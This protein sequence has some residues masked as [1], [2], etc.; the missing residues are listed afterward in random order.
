VF[1][2]LSGAQSGDVSNEGLK[3]AVERAVSIS[4]G[5]FRFLNQE[6][7]CERGIAWDNP[8]LS[9]LYR[10]HLHYFDYVEDFML[11]AVAGAQ[12]AAWDAFRELVSS[13]IDHNG[14]FQGDGW[15]PYTVSLRI[16]NWVNALGFWRAAFQKDAAF[17]EYFLS[18]LYGQARFLAHNLEYDV[19]GNH[20][21]KNLKGL[22]WAGKAFEGKEPQSW[23]E[24]AIG[25]LEEELA[26]QVLGDGGHFERAPGYHG[27]VLADCMEMGLWLRR[28]G[29][30]APEWL[31]AAIG[32]ML[33]FLRA[34]LPF[35]HR[36]PLLKD[37][38]WNVGRPAVDLLSTGALYLNCAALK[39]T[40]D[41]GLYPWLLFGARGRERF[42]ELRLSDAPTTSKPLF[43]SGF[44]VSRDEERKD[45]LIFDAGKPCPDYL[46]AHAHADMFSY[47]LT[48]RGQRVVVDSGVYEYASGKWR[49]FFRST[50][51][52]NTVEINGKN[53]SEVWG[54]FR[55][56]QRA[57]PG[58]VRYRATED[59]AVI[60]AWH[61]G[62]QRLGIDAVHR[63]VL[64]WEKGRYW[65]FFDE[66]VGKGCVQARSF[67]H[68]H[69]SFAF[70]AL[71]S[72][73]FQIYGHGEFPLAL[74][75]FGNDMHQIVTGRE[76]GEIQGWYS[77]E[78][79]KR[80]PNSVLCLEKAGELPFCFGYMLSVEPVIQI[81]FAQKGP[82][83]YDFRFTMADKT[84]AIAVEPEEVM[85]RS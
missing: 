56:A 45:F 16:V 36:F 59:Y 27:M 61:D 53:Q 78:F 52:H 83:R 51:A 32:R 6:M 58:P 5:K 79:G 71:N 85:V 10:Y 54:S 2:G 4:K 74:Q 55:V 49:D 11:W 75:S 35:D 72:G 81:E 9:Q 25:G 13:W 67:V 65:F 76:Q 19:R 63:R 62:Y 28:N 18:S 14:R 69:P 33:D 40:G 42:S 77:E 50:R 57:R 12:G 39:I 41:L 64:A 84:L 38:A 73:L 47:E 43:A 80:A 24:S 34:I 44:F 48:V 3:A 31:E 23:C 21:I 30:K 7:S 82:R 37:T 17:S 66:I 20:L 22:L 26:E 15:H 1:V 68:L 70:K 60:D 29:G 46:P 8:S